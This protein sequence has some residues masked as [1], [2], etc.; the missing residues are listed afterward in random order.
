MKALASMPVDN[1][2]RLRAKYNRPYAQNA[3]KHYEEKY[4]V[5][6]EAL[7]L[8]G[9]SLDAARTKQQEELQDLFDTVVFEIE[10]RQQFLEEM[11]GGNK[12]VEERV[13]KEIIDRIAEL[14]KIKELQHKEYKK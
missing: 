6:P 8:P 11:S 2:A 12:Q 10:D 5:N 7:L 14:Q 9:G 3:M 4:G 13:K 1:K